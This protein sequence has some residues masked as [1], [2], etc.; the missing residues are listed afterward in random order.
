MGETLRYVAPANANPA[1][2]QCDSFELPVPDSA[3]PRATSGGTRRLVGDW[4]ARFGHP[5][6]L[7]ETLSLRK[8]YATDNLQQILSRRAILAQVW[9]NVSPDGCVPA[10]EV[11]SS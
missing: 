7:V 8:Q 5:L 6:L 3:L 10:L 1:A 4:P 9:L 11:P 2:E